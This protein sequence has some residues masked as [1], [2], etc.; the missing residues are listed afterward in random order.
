MELLVCRQTWK[1][2]QDWHKGCVFL[3]KYRWQNGRHAD[4]QQRN[5]RGLFLS[6]ILKNSVFKVTQD[7]NVWGS[8]PTP[9][10]VIR[11]VTMATSFKK[12]CNV[13][14]RG[15]N[16]TVSFNKSHYILSTNLWITQT[17]CCESVSFFKATVP[18]NPQIQRNGGTIE[19]GRYLNIR[20]VGYSY[21]DSSSISAQK[22]LAKSEWVLNVIKAIKNL[23]SFFGDKDNY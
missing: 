23:T 10:N 20:V 8:A 4:E 12:R 7:H 5:V 18:P 17:K 11:P 19:S 14:H 9:T 22:I 16:S 3:F 13:G 15:S 21:F 1:E 6:G 2:Q